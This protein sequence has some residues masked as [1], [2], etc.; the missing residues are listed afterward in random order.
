MLSP[1]NNNDLPH[2][3]AALTVQNFVLRR[4][5]SCVPDIPRPLI[6][7]FRLNTTE[8]SRQLLVARTFFSIQPSLHP[9]ASG[10]CGLACLDFV[11]YFL[12]PM[13]SFL[14]VCSCWCYS[15]PC[16]VYAFVSFYSLAIV[17]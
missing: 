13:V 17:S 6:L 3:E 7:A 8:E 12:L 1:A 14:G 5:R 4:R 11:F 9:S 15:C 16:F 10:F 2:A